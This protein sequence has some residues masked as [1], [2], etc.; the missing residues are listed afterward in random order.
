[1]KLTSVEKWKL[2]EDAPDSP[3]VWSSLTSRIHMDLP[4]GMRPALSL[5]GS[6]RWH[7]IPIPVLSRV[8]W[9]DLNI[10]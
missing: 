3:L 9:T 4:A 10:K 6:S 5:L 1:M 2:F 7:F 8:Y